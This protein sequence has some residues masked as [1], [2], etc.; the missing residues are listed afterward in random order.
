MSM[1][2]FQQLL[3]LVLS[4]PAMRDDLLKA[5]NLPALFSRTLSIAVERGI[6]L[7]EQELHTLV[8]LNRR[9][10]LERWLEQ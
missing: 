4:D 5:P 1:T 3:Q 6:E 2:G 9:S 7:T 8:D 10:W